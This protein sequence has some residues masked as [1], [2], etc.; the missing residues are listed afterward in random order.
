MDYIIPSIENL[1]TQGYG[2]SYSLIRT[3]I[4]CMD[5]DYTL[6]NRYTVTEL[7]QMRID[8]IILNMYD[9]DY[10]MLNNID[11][12]LKINNIDNPLDI[13]I[14]DVLYYPN[15]DNIKDY[16]I[17]SDGMDDESVIIKA[18]SVPKKTTG[19]DSTR[20]AFLEN[21]GYVI[22]PTV[23]ETAEEPVKVTNNAIVISQQN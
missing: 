14:G 19:V 22:P 12:I 7:D 1:S 5:I 18:L 11:V 2:V 16:R 23:L 9:N 6:L 10:N 3:N 20:K 17:D 21:G 13:N 15:A 4:V 8:T